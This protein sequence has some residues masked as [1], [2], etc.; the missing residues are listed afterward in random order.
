VSDDVPDVLF[1]NDLARL[2][3]MSTRTL[4]ELRKSRANLPPQMVSLDDRPRWAKSTVLAWMAQT[5]VAT[6]FRIARG[7]R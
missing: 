3:R 1:R 2:L 4:D 6:R 5:D 7:G